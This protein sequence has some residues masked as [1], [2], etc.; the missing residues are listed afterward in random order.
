MDQIIKR[1]GRFALHQTAAGFC[2]ELTSQCGDQWFWYPTNRQWTPSCHPSPS[3]KEA[4]TGL[5]WT[6]SHE[7]AGDLDSQHTIHA[8]HPVHH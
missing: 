2:W 6:L 5:D 7:N 3:E 8:G 4:T 1:C